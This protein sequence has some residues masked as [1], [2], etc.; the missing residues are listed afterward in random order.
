MMEEDFDKRLSDHIK[1]VFDDT[2]S[3][4]ADAGWLLLREKYPPKSDRKP[5]AW[6]WWFAAVIVISGLG[7]GVWFGE[8]QAAKK[9]AKQIKVVAKPAN[10]SALQHEQ[11]AKRAAGTFSGKGDKSS[12]VNK[13]AR[14]LINKKQ[15]PTGG[16]HN[17]VSRKANG[18]SNRKQLK[19]TTDKRPYVT[20]QNNHDLAVLAANKTAEPPVPNDQQNDNRAD[21]S[22]TEANAV[23]KPIIMSSRDSAV[24]PAAKKDETT[25]KQ[26]KADTAKKKANTAV[27][28]RIV[29]GVFASAVYSTAAGS[30][31][32][33]NL[34]AGSTVDIRL[35]GHL[36][37]SSGLG[38]MRA[39]LNYSRAPGTY[40]Y[41]YS[42][43]TSSVQVPLPQALVFNN[44]AVKLL[45]LDIPFNLKYSFAKPYNYISA[46]LSSGIYINEHYDQVYTYIPVQAGLP[47]VHQATQYHFG[48]ADL[49]KTFNLSFGLGYPIG[50]QSA[51][52]FEPF[53]KAPI[54]GLGSQ[55]LGY[56]LIGINLKLNF[57]TASK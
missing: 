26:V 34:G 7:T 54:T 21:S 57:K 22:K 2:G 37:F 24:K 13:T 12:E 17:A 42:A 43:S 40:G 25:M 52:I 41:A 49:F 18:T 44:Y 32:E 20:K 6:L 5:V 9:R 27:D 23:T 47:E 53:L 55:Q 19:Q 28:S 4:G 46:G 51:L 48:H 16:P 29:Y 30:D 35:A 8:Q 39:T 3:N 38:I 56:S 36:S 45:A 11:T 50:K 1:D 31:N 10:D 14:A 15:A 33:F